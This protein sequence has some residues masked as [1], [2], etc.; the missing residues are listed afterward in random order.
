[1]WE[2]GDTPDANPRTLRLNHVE[3][4][5]ADEEGFPTQE[6]V[7]LR[8]GQAG[9]TVEGERVIKVGAD[10]HR[11][12]WIRCED[13]DGGQLTPRLVTIDTI[14][15]SRAWNVGGARVIDDPLYDAA[16]HRLWR[17]R[18][19]RWESNTMTDKARGTTFRVVAEERGLRRF[20][21]P[22]AAWQ[23]A[24]ASRSPLTLV[25]E[26]PDPRDCT[27]QVVDSAGRPRPNV[28]VLWMPYDQR[29]PYD[30]S[31]EQGSAT[32]DAEGL[33]PMG[34]L[35]PGFP[36][37]VYAFDPRTRDA[38]RVE[39]Y[40]LETAAGVT[41]V[42]LSPARALDVRV[43]VP[44]GGRLFSAGMVTKP[45]LMLPDVPCRIADGDRIRADPAALECYD[46][47]VGV[48]FGQRR[49]AATFAA[50][51]VQGREIEYPEAK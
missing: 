48:M 22:I 37:R 26:E 50:A 4:T 46:L 17:I 39:D 41:R 15:D 1:V 49:V 25:F 24:S 5:Y 34:H 6:N 10:V 42:T 2:V 43:R 36:Y 30:W 45:R 11:D 35:A 12:I 31:H 16:G 19:L 3:V 28:V 20:D 44:Q 38:G 47:M 33:L 40:R 23:A 51:E 29:S 21:V 14:S 7:D 13:A 18:G 9:V 27:V 32:A 8:V